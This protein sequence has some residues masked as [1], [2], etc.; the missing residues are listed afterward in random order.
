MQETAYN[1]FVFVEGDTVTGIGVT[2]HE[3]DGGE[4]EKIAFLQS[5][6][7]ADFGRASRYPLPAPK[8]R[9]WLQLGSD[10]KI[11]FEVFSYLSRTGNGLRVFED[12][13][14]DVGAPAEPLVCITPIKDGRPCVEAVSHVDPTSVRGSMVASEFEAAVH[15]TDYLGR[16]VTEQGL[17]LDALLED[18]FL[19]AIKLLH[20]R[21]HYV[22]AMKL[23]V[24]FVDT[25]AYLEYGDSQG[26]FKEWV[27]HYADIQPVGL[28]P[29]E[30]WEFRNAVLHMTNPHSRKVLAGKEPALC[31]YSG[32]TE[33]QSLSDELTGRKMFSFEALYESVVAGIDRW[34]GTYSGDLQKQLQLIRRYDEILSE[35]R[36][37]GLSRAEE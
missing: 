6:V 28:T 37:A 10:D 20:H 18:D 5:Q 14:Q 26:N 27:T 15:K 4:G 36:V 29:S 8:I 13:L 19:A 9:T 1:L 34:A 12:L 22:S 21:S 30:I 17:S 3:L 23:L 33:R 32:G 2:C 25:L 11:T 35:G 16:Y 7:Q 24:S 31:F